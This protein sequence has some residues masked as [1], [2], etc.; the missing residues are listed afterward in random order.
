VA[1]EQSPLLYRYNGEGFDVLP[2][3]QGDA[4]RRYVIGEVYAGI[5]RDVR[6]MDSH[7]HYFACLNEAWTNLPEHLTQQFP[8]AEHLRKFALIQCNFYKVRNYVARDAEDALAVVEL[9]RP[10]D[11]FA[12]VTAK[13][14]VVSIYTAESQSTNSPPVGMGNKRFKE[15]KWAVL[16]YAADLIGITVEELVRRG[17]EKTKPRAARRKAE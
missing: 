9:I 11:E 7:R 8:S 3:F 13:G 17:K 12:V 5:F 14:T 15:S 1:D 10:Y 6:D 4:D 16:E 2:R